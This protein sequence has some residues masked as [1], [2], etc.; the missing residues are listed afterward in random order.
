MK[1]TFDRTKPKV[2]VKSTVSMVENIVV[3]ALAISHHKTPKPLPKKP[4]DN[5][6]WI[7]RSK[8]SIY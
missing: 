6:F 4:K 3:I 2:T 8:R 5:G 1:E 7:N